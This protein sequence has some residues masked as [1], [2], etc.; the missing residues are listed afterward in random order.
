MDFTKA[1]PVGAHIDAQD[2]QLKIAGGYDHTFVLQT[3]N[4]LREAAKLHEPTTG[5]VLEVLT[6]QPGIQFYSGNFLDGSIV[7]KRGRAYVQRSGCCLEPQHFPDSP[8][9]PSFPSTRLQPE[10]CRRQTTVLKFSVM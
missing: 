10:E 5:R 2:E 8:N 9:Q 4:R 7:G 1:T 6:D 3:G